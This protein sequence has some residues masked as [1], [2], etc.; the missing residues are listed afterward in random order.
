MIG[1]KRTMRPQAETGSMAFR[2]T[3]VPDRQTA[4]A[5]RPSKGIY[6][7]E[8]WER[9]W[10]KRCRG[11]RDVEEGERDGVWGERLEGEV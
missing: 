2:M 8:R 6:D 11:G 3:G 10:R 1:Y 9:D 4:Q 7:P 5:D